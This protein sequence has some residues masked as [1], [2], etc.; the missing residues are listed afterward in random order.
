VVVAVWDSLELSGGLIKQPVCI[1]DSRKRMI[2]LIGS[3]RNAEIPKIA[4]KLRA[5]GIDVFDDWY[6]A[7]PNADDCWRDYERD[8]GHSFRDALAG[9]AARNVFHFDKRNLEASDGAI[10]VCPAGKSGHLELGWILGQGKPGYILLDSPDR[11][12]VMYQ[13]AT[14]VTDNLDEIA[15]ECLKYTTNTTETHQQM[16]FTWD[17]EVPLETLSAT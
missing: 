17:E 9:A 2:Y 4:Y 5:R 15:E 13:F 7:G 1:V 3:L 14:L 16:P 6:A 11:W 10:L 8:R 12:D